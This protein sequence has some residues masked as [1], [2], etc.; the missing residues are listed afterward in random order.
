[1][2]GDTGPIVYGVGAAATGLGIAAARVM[3]DEALAARFERTAVAVELAAGATVVATP[4]V[5]AA[6]AD[7][8]RYLGAHVRPRRG[9]R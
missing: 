2:D 9:A 1:M 5:H 4:Y 7:A 8:I 3:G 6:L